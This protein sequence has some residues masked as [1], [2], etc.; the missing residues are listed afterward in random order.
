M[1]ITSKNRSIRWYVELDVSIIT[2]KNKC[3]FIVLFRTKI[4]RCHVMNTFPRWWY[5]M[6]ADVLNIIINIFVEFFIQY[7]R[8]YILRLLIRTQKWGL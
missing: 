6:K 4:I 8:R 5:Q 3:M 1:T 7:M 2:K